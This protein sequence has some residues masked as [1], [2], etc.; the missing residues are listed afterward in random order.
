MFDKGH[1]HQRIQCSHFIASGMRTDAE[2]SSNRF[3]FFL[4]TLRCKERKGTSDAS[5]TV[6]KW[7]T[8]ASEFQSQAM[9]L[10]GASTRCWRY[11]PLSWPPGFASCTG[12]QSLLLH[13]GAFLATYRWNDD[14]NEHDCPFVSTEPRVDLQRNCRVIVRRPVPFLNHVQAVC[15]PLLSFVP[16]TEQ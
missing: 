5:R 13:G 12:M 6:N 1:L 7:S 2:A 9:R 16:A 4:A 8:I 3:S 11:R 14:H 10:M 15:L